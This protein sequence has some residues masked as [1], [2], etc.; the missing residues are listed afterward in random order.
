MCGRMSWRGA[1]LVVANG[2][3]VYDTMAGAAVTVSGDADVGNSQSS[4]GCL[5]CAVPIIRYEPGEN[6]SH[7]GF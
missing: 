7:R 6:D 2:G 1:L 5:V 4:S 3:E